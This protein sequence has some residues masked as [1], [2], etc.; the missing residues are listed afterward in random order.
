[1]F[2]S[3]DSSFYRRTKHQFRLEVRTFLQEQ[4][5]NGIFQ[6]KCDAWLSGSNPQFFK[7]NW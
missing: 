4:L 3:T 7:N 2:Q 5:A 1:M 6:T